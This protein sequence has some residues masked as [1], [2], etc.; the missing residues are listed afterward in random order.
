[1]TKLLSLYGKTVTL[2]VTVFVVSFSVLALAFLSISASEERDQVRDLEKVI[3]S[4]NSGVREFMITRNPQDAKDTE[5]LL[6]KADMTVR[7]GIREENYQRLRNEVLLYLHSINDLIEAYRERG[8]FEDAGVEGRMRDRLNRLENDLLQAGATEAH[9]ALLLARR[10]EKNYMLR[11]R[12]EYVSEVHDRIDFLMSE[13]QG[14]SLSP[15]EFERFDAELGDYQQDFDQLVS[16]VER[17]QWI[18]SNLEFVQAAIG[19]T[20]THVISQEQQRARRYLWLCLGLM[21]SAFLLGIIYSLFVANSILSPL[22]KLRKV[23]GQSAQGDDVDWKTLAELNVANE[24]IG[25]VFSSFQDVQ[26]QVRLREEA[27]QDLQVSKEALQ[28]YAN[29]LEQRTEQLDVAVEQLQSAKTDAE[30][31]SRNKAEFLAS[32][33]HEI[34]TPLNGI[35]GMTSL[36]DVENMPGE[37]REVVEVIRTSGESLLS[38]VNHVLDFSKIEAGGMSLE[39]EPMSVRAN[40]EDALGM[41][42]RQAA[43][44]GLD[45]SCSFE[46]CIPEEIMGDAA[47]MRQILIN[48]LGNAVKF[49]HEGE[50]QVRVH[51]E[52]REDH[53][54]QLHF[55]V[56]DTG[57]G[58]DA[59]H[60]DRLFEPFKQAEASTARRFGGT[61]LGLTISKRL[62]EMMDGSMWVTS[63]LGRG[64]T[65]HFTTI[66][67]VSDTSRAPEFREVP[68]DQRVLFLTKRPLIARAVESAFKPYG[69]GVDLASDE[70]E[71]SVRLSDATYFAVFINEC[72]TGFDGVA[73]TAIARMLKSSAPNTPFVV[74]RHI[75]QQMGD[76][77]TECMIKPLRSSTLREFVRRNMEDAEA[78]GNIIPI[79]GSNGSN[80]SEV[81][82]KIHTVGTMDRPPVM[83]NARKVLLVEDNVVNQKVGVRMLERLGCDVDVVDRGEK[84]IKAVISGRYSHVFMDLSMPGMDGLEATREIRNLPETIKQPVIIALTANATTGDRVKCLEAGMDDYASKPV[85]P[86]T[87]KVLL[88]RYPAQPDPIGGDGAATPSGPPSLSNE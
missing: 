78:A 22:D 75:H 15:S 45:L 52:E 87:L 55:E 63:E 47:R 41:V 83:L 23:I 68:G 70:E 7:E 48:L 56:E 36:L 58:I 51:C 19:G 13:L 79:S 14:S 18:R 6:Q 72:S 39:T 69:L 24:D 31:E 73:G 76:S 38:I 10:A 30:S 16:L 62:A 46:T 59:D 11:E 84:A 77:T 65:F 12:P 35:I 44:K 28:R 61:G 29:E 21:L 32:M 1:M 81:T 88:D 8:F 33:S 9:A 60:M 53:T 74:M 37:Q 5:L 67:A 66:H 4:A 20:L 3:L 34:R 50:V 86:N 17:T 25:Q 71:A 26:E 49:T 80:G 42:S 43:E 27:E 54:I 40:V 82:A 64:S 85:D 2:I 57:I